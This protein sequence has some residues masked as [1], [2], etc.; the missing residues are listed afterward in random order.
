MSAAGKGCSTNSTPSRISSGMSSRADSSVQPSLA[1]TRIARVGRLLAHGL[2]PLEVLG[3]ADLDLQR[4]ELA[5]RARTRS[6]V[7]STVSMPIVNEVCG[8]RGESPS[9]RHSGTPSR[10]PIQS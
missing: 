5:G 8:A 10:L 7:P 2:E 4:A 3:A 1:S 9:S 6:R